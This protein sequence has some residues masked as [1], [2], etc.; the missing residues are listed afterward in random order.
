ME[1]DYRLLQTIHRILRQ[2]TDLNER[3]EKGPRRVK[4]AEAAETNF[5]QELEQAISPLNEVLFV[6]ANPM[7]VKYALAKV[8]RI[9]EGIRLPLTWPEGEIAARIDAVLERYSW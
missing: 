7:P 1:I 2:R 5:V 6:E 3:L 8:G 4:I 9:P